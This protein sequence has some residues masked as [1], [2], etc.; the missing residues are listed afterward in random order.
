MRYTVVL[1]LSHGGDTAVRVLGQEPVAYEAEPGTG[2]LFK[3]ALWHRTERASEG[4]M[5]LALFFGRWL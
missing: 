1:L 4:T 2:V 5:K 3:S